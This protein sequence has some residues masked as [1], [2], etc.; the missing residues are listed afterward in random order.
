MKVDSKG[1]LS[2][3][4]QSRHRPRGHSSAQSRFG[5]LNLCEFEMSPCPGRDAEWAAVCR[6]RRPAL[7]SGTSSLV[8]I[9]PVG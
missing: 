2:A 6:S 4:G 5:R 7:V 9:P 3:K 1:L 8:T